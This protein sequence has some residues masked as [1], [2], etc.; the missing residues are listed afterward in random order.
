MPKKQTPNPI[1]KPAPPVRQSV[2]LPPP[3]TFEYQAFGFLA[4]TLSEKGDPSLLLNSGEALT[5]KGLD[6]RLRRWL[7]TQEQPISGYFGLYPKSTRTGPTFWVK[8]FQAEE[9]EIEPGV[10]LIDGQLFSTKGETHLFRIHRNQ[11]NSLE[12][13]NLIRV[14]GFLPQAKPGQFWKLECLWEAGQF[15]IQDGYRL[16]LS[17]H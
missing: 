3:S 8:S 15:A 4:G 1:R 5:V 14:S 17:A 11:S 12:K 13:P 10:F 9:P 6:E 2:F 7:D 16:S